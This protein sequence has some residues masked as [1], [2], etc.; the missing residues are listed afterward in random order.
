MNQPLLSLFFVEMKLYENF[1]SKYRAYRDLEE[2]LSKMRKNFAGKDRELKYDPTMFLKNP[3]L[4]SKFKIKD[5]TSK[6]FPVLQIEESKGFQEKISTKNET[7]NSFDFTNVF[8]SHVIDSNFSNEKYEIK[9]T[10]NEQI[11]P[12]FLDEKNI[13]LAGISCDPFENVKLSSLTKSKERRETFPEVPTLNLSDFFGKPISQGLLEENIKINNNINN[14]HQFT[15]PGLELKVSENP[16]KIRSDVENDDEKKSKISY[17]TLKSV[18]N[19]DELPSY[20]KVSNYAQSIF[21]RAQ[22]DTSTQMTQSN[23]INIEDFFKPAIEMATPKNI[24]VNKKS[25]DFG[26]LTNVNNTKSF[27][28]PKKQIIDPFAGFY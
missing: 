1:S 27:N 25:A 18:L 23:E 7:P 4:E 14:N 24:Y 17:P 15:R 11:Y 9:I 8:P 6:K 21:S 20:R 5:V 13:P 10:S 2:K 22:K 16:F 3:Y 19:N 26:S 12:N 28:N